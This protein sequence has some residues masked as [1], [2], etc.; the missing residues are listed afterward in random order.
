[1]SELKR[2]VT[3]LV[4]AGLVVLGIV[5]L[6]LIFLPVV[7][8]SFEPGVGLK[9][10]SIIGF[11]VTTT[12]FIVLAIFAGDGL[13]GEIQFMIGGFLLFYLIFTVMIAWVF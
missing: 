13:L 8:Q 2:D 11:F 5:L 7:V 6:A 1:M 9:M 10:A 12:L 3:L 4:I